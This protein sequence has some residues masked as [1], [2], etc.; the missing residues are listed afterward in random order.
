VRLPDGNYT[1]E[2]QNVDHDFSKALQVLGCKVAFTMSS[3][4]TAALFDQ[5]TPFQTEVQVQPRGL[6]LPII[7]SITELAYGSPAVTKK[8][9][10]CILR[11]ERC[12]L[13]WN[14]SVEGILVHG[15][16]VEAILVG[17]VSSSSSDE[18][19]PILT[20]MIDLGFSNRNYEWHSILFPITTS[21]T[22]S[23]SHPITN[24]F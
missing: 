22:N 8:S 9:Y 11:A 2:P 18:L 14:D 16:D 20:N 21:A 15:T 4:I 3:D 19:T 13:V 17:L 6:K 10:I 12:V 23:R 5:I 24:K 1:T 7:N